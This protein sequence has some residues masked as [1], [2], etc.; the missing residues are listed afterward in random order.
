MPH[1]SEPQVTNSRRSGLLER[2]IIIHVGHSKTGSSSI[3]QM[4]TSERDRLER[5]GLLYPQSN[6]GRR[7]HRSL[8]F[9]VIGTVNFGTS[10][11][12][13]LFIKMSAEE[14]G[15]MRKSASE[16]RFFTRQCNQSNAGTVL[17]SAE[18][19]FGILNRDCAARLKKRLEKIPHTCLRVV[20]YVRS[21]ALFYLSMVQQRL[22]GGHG[23]PAPKAF[24]R[25]ASIESYRRNLGV[26]LEAKV[27]ERHNLK[28]GDVVQ[29]FLERIG[30]S[31]F[32]P[33]VP[34]SVE[35]ESVSA[36]AMDVLSKLGADK[37]PVNQEELKRQR[38][39]TRIVKRIDELLPEPTKPV[40]R[41]EV[42]ALVVHL[43]SDLLS[44]RDDYGLVF[45]D[46]DYDQA[47]KGPE[48]VAP[49]I[50]TV[51]DLCHFDTAR[52]ADLQS[53]VMDKLQKR[54]LS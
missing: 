45:S 47:S 18:G 27:F 5:H 24:E 50:E 19:L 7:N 20:G 44:L 43:N 26:H 53:A 42:A 14:G 28:N 39:L 51:A 22:K 35:N 17:L 40:L 30:F 9:D 49:K 36:E 1:T 29:D 12:T 15:A 16:W 41:S 8:M 46:V 2:Q 32:S 48:A 4:L 37:S 21:P 34:P 31:H 23:L 3:Q 25:A 52:S 11:N 13:G 10:V 6:I 33:Q 54:G 38:L